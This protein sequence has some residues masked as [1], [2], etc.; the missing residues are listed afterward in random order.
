MVIPT[1]YS[2]PELLPQSIDSVLGQVGAKAA[3]ANGG[4]G[5]PLSVE[6]LIY[7]PAR[8]VEELAARFARPGVTVLAEAEGVGL[9]ENI[10]I[11]LRE[12]AARAEFIGWLGDDDLLT[13]GSLAACVAALRAEP[14]VAMVYGGCDYIDPDGRV[15]VTNRSG[16]WA[17]GLLHFGPQ[18][19]PQPGSLWRASAYLKTDGLDPAFNLAFDFDLFL[20]LKRIGR[21]RYL[22]TTLAQFRWHPDSLS[23]RRR[24]VSVTEASRVRRKHYRGLMRVLWPLWEPWVVIATWAAGKLL[25]LRLR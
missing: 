16:Q 18:L 24:W 11:G 4:D 12:A 25:S 22:P 14:E 17:A 7:C 13:P 10:D 6:L 1:I 23:V 5:A 20:K 15:L 3:E 19:I 9:A 2:R 8:L 21:L